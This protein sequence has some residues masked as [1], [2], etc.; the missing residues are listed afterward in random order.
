MN[1]KIETIYLKMTY[2]GRFVQVLA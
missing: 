2:L 1:K